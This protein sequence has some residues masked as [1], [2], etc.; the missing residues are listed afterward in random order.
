MLGDGTSGAD[1]IRGKGGPLL[2]VKKDIAD[3]P[4]SPS[5]Q[6]PSSAAPVLGRDA[7]QH[8]QLRP[9]PT[10]STGFSM[11][12]SIGPYDPQNYR[13]IMINNSIQQRIWQYRDCFR[14]V[15]QGSS[16]VPRPFVK[17]ILCRVDGAAS[18]S[19]GM[20]DAICS[21][22]DVEEARS[23]RMER[24]STGMRSTRFGTNDRSAVIGTILRNLRACAQEAM[25]E[26]VQV[27]AGARASAASFGPEVRAVV[28]RG[29]RL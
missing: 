13:T 15:V 5:S 3:R 18:W 1:I 26:A 25:A 10:S 19:D 27:A 11:L 29:I 12:N 17:D 7:A 4:S 16:V 9:R 22:A 2:T 24:P 28:A 21:G 14:S 6:R 23:H 8:K 20:V